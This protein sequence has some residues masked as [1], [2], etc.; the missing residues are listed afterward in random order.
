MDRR[1]CR[2][3]RSRRGLVVIY[4]SPLTRGIFYAILTVLRYMVQL[5]LT[6]QFAIHR[7]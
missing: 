7:R 1:K 6:I 4:E 2:F 3:G 5:V